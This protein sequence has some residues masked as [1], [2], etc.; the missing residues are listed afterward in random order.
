MKNACELC[1]ILDIDFGRCY[2]FAEK[3]KT[4][5]KEKLL[6]LYFENPRL[7]WMNLDYWQ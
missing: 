3:N 1:E 6:D 2:K 7:L 4:L 5:N